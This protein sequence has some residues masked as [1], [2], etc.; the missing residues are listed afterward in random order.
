[1]KNITNRQKIIIG[2]LALLLMIAAMVFILHTQ[3]QKPDPASERI[4]REL[5]ERELS[6][7]TKIRKDPNSLTDEDFAQII[8]FYIVN[9]EL[10][11]IKLLEK[12]KNLQRLHL[13][14]IHYPANKIPKWMSLLAKLGLFNLEERFAFDLSP[15]EKLANLQILYIW[16]TDVSD[17]KPLANCT[18]LRNLNFSGT[19][20]SY[21]KPLANMK[22]L[23][24][25]SLTNMQVSDEQVA[26][27]KK[28]LPNVSISR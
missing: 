19:N 15:L 6:S 17:I 10:C 2:I 9:T 28:A 27:L 13:D 3:E 22:N 12:F 16:N 25:L 4:I 23:R 24:G 26:E 18:N 1:M 14:N 7:I 20:V 21:I 8:R 5:A 11:D